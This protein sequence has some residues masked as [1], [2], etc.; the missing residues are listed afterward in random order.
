MRRIVVIV[1][2]FISAASAY[3]YLVSHIH[4]KEG[5]PLR[6]D[7][8]VHNFGK[9][10]WG[11]PV[12][13]KFRFLNASQQEVAI[14]HITTSCACAVAYLSSHR[15]RPGE[16][17]ILTVRFL[18]T[19]FVGQVTQTLQIY[20]KGFRNPVNLHLKADVN[21]LLMPSPSKIDFGLISPQRQVSTMLVIKNTSGRKVRITRIETSREY[22]KAFVLKDGDEPLIRVSLV[23]PPVGKVYDRLYI[24]TSLP[25]RSIIDVP[26][27]AEVTCKWQLSDTEFFFGFVNRGER[28]T[29]RITVKGLRPESIKKVWTD[30][31]LATVGFIPNKAGIEVFVHLDLTKSKG[32]EEIEKNVYIETTD[33]EQPLLR[34]PIVGFIQDPD[35]VEEC[36]SEGKKV[37]DDEP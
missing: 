3:R 7:R 23:H 17:G 13:A 20:L 9:V 19:G 32:D 18:P 14:E 36:C 6:F 15:F 22:V 16:Q 21:P 31:P 30:C 25:E 26:I 2:L 1:F 29:R 28:L 34:L 11:N 4:F 10:A 24:Y 35:R 12:E 27:K 37:S 8:T 5:F 33:N